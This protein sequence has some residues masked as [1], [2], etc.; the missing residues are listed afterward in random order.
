MLLR[1]GGSWGAAFEVVRRETFLVHEEQSQ[2]REGDTVLAECRGAAWCSAQPSCFASG[3]A[4][5]KEL[6]R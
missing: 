5:C 2:D 6:Q 3:S 4:A 1:E